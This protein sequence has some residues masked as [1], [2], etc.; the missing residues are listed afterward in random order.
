[1][2][3][4][5]TLDDA[6]SLCS[7]PSDFARMAL[8]KHAPQ[9]LLLRFQKGRRFRVSVFRQLQHQVLPVGEAFVVGVEIE[10]LHS[11]RHGVGDSFAEAHSASADVAATVNGEWFAYFAPPGADSNRLADATKVTAT[12]SNGDVSQLIQHG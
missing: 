12:T 6:A 8:L 3:R 1:M 4:V 7:G 5:K 11:G 9:N 10:F 2:S